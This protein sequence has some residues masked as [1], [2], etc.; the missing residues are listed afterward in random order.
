[1]AGTV[2]GR[3]AGLGDLLE[4]PAHQLGFEQREAALEAIGA[5]SPRP[6]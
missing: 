6:G 4:R 1:M 2:I 5:A 3:E